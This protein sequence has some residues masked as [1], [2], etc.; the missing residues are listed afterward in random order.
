MTPTELHTLVRGWWEQMRDIARAATQGP[1]F[2]TPTMTVRTKSSLRSS[3]LVAECFNPRSTAHIA[4]FDPAFAIAVCE[5]ALERLDRHA[6][7]WPIGYDDVTEASCTT[8]I[9]Q[10]PDGEYSVPNWP[11]VEFLADAA[12]FRT[13]PNF[14]EELS[15]DQLR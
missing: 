9:E 5:A 6:P 1:W 14:P 7:A 12:P 13:R 10:L 4:A 15:R 11:C 3:P 2:A 8:C